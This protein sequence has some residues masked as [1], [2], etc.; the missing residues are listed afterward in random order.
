MEHVCLSDDSDWSPPLTADSVTPFI[1][2]GPFLTPNRREFDAE[3]TTLNFQ[4]T[5]KAQF[6]TRLSL[7]YPKLAGFSVDSPR[8]KPLFRGFEGPSVAR[9]AILTVLCLIAYPT[10]YILTL[11]ARDKPLFTVRLIVSTCYSGVAFALGY[12]LL[13]I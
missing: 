12:T 11:V 5:D 10:L 1:H 13:S 8:S 4:Y 3:E 7:S 6:S 9:I 2:A